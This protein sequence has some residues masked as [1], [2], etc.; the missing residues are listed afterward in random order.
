MHDLIPLFPNMKAQ[1]ENE[2]FEG[3]EYLKSPSNVVEDIGVKVVELRE[4]A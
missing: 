3:M 2:L 1:V 4:I